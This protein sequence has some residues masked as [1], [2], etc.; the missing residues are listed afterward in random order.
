VWEGFWS[1]VA[2]RRQGLR[3][4][5]NMLALLALLVPLRRSLE[6]EVNGVV[7]SR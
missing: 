3:A 5:R 6:L 4:R 2:R 7:K 1:S